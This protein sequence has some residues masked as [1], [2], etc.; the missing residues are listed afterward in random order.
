MAARGQAVSATS[1]DRL[2]ERFP[3]VTDRFTAIVG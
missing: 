2:R 3:L 1:D